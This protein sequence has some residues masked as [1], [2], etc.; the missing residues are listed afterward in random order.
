MDTEKT[1]HRC[2]VAFF[3]GFII[4]SSKCPHMIKNSKVDIKKELNKEFSIGFS[5][6]DMG[7]F[8]SNVTLIQIIYNRLRHKK[9]HTKTFKSDQN[10]LNS[11]FMSLEGLKFIK[12]IKRLY[13]FDINLINPKNER[14]DIPIEM[15][16]EIIKTV[17]RYGSL[18]S[19]FLNFNCFNRAAFHSDTLPLGQFPNDHWYWINK[20]AT[21]KEG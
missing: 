14:I 9:S 20:I 2:V 13:N 4:G 12:F 16:E 3:K 5:L 11:F 6:G 8:V 10:I 18:T 1:N 7:D 21:F 19:S 17:K 15:I